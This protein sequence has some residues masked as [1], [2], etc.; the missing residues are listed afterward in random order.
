MSQHSHSCYFNRRYALYRQVLKGGKQL[1]VGEGRK[2]K[3]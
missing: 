1:P 3:I 2:E